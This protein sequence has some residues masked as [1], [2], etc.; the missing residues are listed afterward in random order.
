MTLKKLYF[1]VWKGAG[2]CTHILEGHSDGIT[3]VSVLNPEG[4]KTDFPSHAT[5]CQILVE[6]LSIS[7]KNITSFVC[8]GHQIQYHYIKLSI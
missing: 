5:N 6:A 4:I 7:V 8:I 1:R 2:L 3:S